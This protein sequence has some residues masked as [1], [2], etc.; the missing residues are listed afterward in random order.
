MFYAARDRWMVEEVANRRWKSGRR[1]R[2]RANTIPTMYHVSYHLVSTKIQSE[3]R[4][5]LVGMG[6]L[7]YW[8]S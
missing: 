2:A 7:P 8:R 3:H 1:I 6:H 4:K 5:L